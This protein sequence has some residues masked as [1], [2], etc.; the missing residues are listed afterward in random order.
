MKKLPTLIR[1]HQLT[2]ALAISA[3]QSA[4]VLPTS[5]AMVQWVYL[6]C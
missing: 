1:L 3:E 6:T 2:M 5:M 4:I